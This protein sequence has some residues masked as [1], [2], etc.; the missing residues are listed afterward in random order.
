MKLDDALQGVTRLAFDT[1]PII[2]FA[3]ANPTYDDLV[4]N[5]FNRVA[6]GSLEA[7]TSVINDHSMRRVTELSILILDDLE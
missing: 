6:S 3:E 4:S 1:A 2:Y 7:W 5:I